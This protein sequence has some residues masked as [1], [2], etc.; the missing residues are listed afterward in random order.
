MY[1]VDRSVHYTPIPWVVDDG[2]IIP[3]HLLA[4]RFEDA[5]NLPIPGVGIQKRLE[6]K[7]EENDEAEHPKQDK[8]QNCISGLF[9]R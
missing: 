5:E 3:E 1:A 2:D 6:P 9:H 8:T 7:T 4:L